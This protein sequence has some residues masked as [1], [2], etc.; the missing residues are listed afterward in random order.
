M[1]TRRKYGLPPF[2]EG[3]VRE[4][5]YMRWLQRKAE[6]HAKRDK[7]RFPHACLTVS[8]FKLRIHEAVLHSG[9]SDFYTGKQLAWEKLSLYNN[10]SSKEHRHRY[11]KEFNL[12]PTVDHEFTGKDEFVVRICAWITNDCKNRLSHAEFIELCE[13][14][15]HH[16][17]KGS[18]QEGSA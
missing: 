12:L 17:K 2:L 9:G 16:H 18:L 4:E 14:V 5:W 10:S 13:A 8:A 3:R 15:L 11:M 6:A 1:K 7:K